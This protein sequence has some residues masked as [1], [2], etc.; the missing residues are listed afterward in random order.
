[1][2]RLVFFVLLA[3]CTV[4]SEEPVK[5]EVAA[6]GY[7]PP[8]ESQPVYGYDQPAYQPSAYQQPFY[9][10]QMMMPPFALPTYDGRPEEH[11]WPTAQ[12]MPHSR[13]LE[14]GDLGP[15]K[16]EV[17]AGGY[18]PP[19]ESQPVYGY[20]Q[21]AYQPPAYQQPFYQPQMM[22]PPFA[23]PTYDVAYCSVHASFPL[24][25]ARRSRGGDH[26]GHGHRL[27]KFERQSCRYTAV[28][29]WEACNTCCKIAS[30]TNGNADM[31]EIVGALFVFDPDM[32]FRRDD[33]KPENS[34]NKAVQCVCCAPKKF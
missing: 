15:V 23:L 33:D 19:P 16:E 30:R 6:G 31:H 20:D 29:S 25:G 2:Q 26:H 34:K 17:A 13:L 12:S 14:P 9:Q 3:A 5:E 32:D 10:P 4:N 8:P 7:Y 11:K 24:V 21:P 22:M 27:R 18:Y 1:M 28:F